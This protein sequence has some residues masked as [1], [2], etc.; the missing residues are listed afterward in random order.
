[1]S[2]IIQTQKGPLTK[3]YGDAQ[4]A[5]KSDVTVRVNGSE[6]TVDSVNPLEGEITL[7]NPVSPADEVEIDYY[8]TD[9]PIVE[10]EFNK[11]GILFNQNGSSNGNRFP[12]DSKFWSEKRSQPIRYDWTYNAYD[13]EYS[14]VFNDPTSL[15]F[16]EE[17]H[18][19]HVPAFSRRT[20]Q[21]SFL[22]EGD[23]NPIGWNKQGSGVSSP[24]FEQGLFV[25]EDSSSGYDGQAEFY[26][27][28]KD[29]TYEYVSLYGFRN[30]VLSYTKD[31]DFS[32]VATG[33]ADEG[34]LYFLGFLEVNGFRFVGL[35]SDAGDETSWSS[36]Q[37]YTTNSQQ[38]T[39]NGSTK[40]DQ[41]VFSREPSF[42]DGDA[43]FIDGSVYKVDSVT[44][45]SGNWNV[46]L[47]AEIGKTG[48]LEVFPEIDWTEL[49]SYR[50]TR[51][52]DGSVE[53]FS[54]SQS[55]PVANLVLSDAP[56]QPEVFELLESNQL[57]FGSLSRDATNKVGW[58]FARYSF[59]PFR[60]SI[61]QEQQVFVESDFASKKPEEDENNPWFLDDNQG[62]SKLVNPDSLLIEQAGRANSGSYTYS[63]IEPF[64]GQNNKVKLTTNIRAE[65]YADGIASA[66]T[67]ADPFKEVTVA[68]LSD[69]SST[70][71]TDYA[72]YR[73]TGGKIQNNA[74]S[75]MGYIAPVTNDN[76]IFKYK[77]AFSGA[78]YFSNE[79]WTSDLQNEATLSFQDHH[80]NIQPGSSEGEAS[81]E[82]NVLSGTN[83]FDNYLNSA[84]IRINDVD[85]DGNGR[86]PLWFG[87]NDGLDGVFLSFIEESGTNKVAFVREDGSIVRDSLGDS[88]SVAFDWDDNTFH[89]YRVIRSGNTIT[90]FID[91]S[92][93]GLTVL[94]SELEDSTRTDLRTS[95]HTGTTDGSFDVDYF[96]SHSTEYADQ[97]IGLFTGTDPNNPDHYEKMPYDWLGSYVELRVLKDASGRTEV[98]VDGS[99]TPLF[100]KQH[101]E[102]PDRTDRPEIGTDLGYVQFG[103]PDPGS[104]SH[105]LWDDISY[106]IQNFREFQ[107]INRQARYNT[108]NVNTS[109][110]PIFDQDP[111]V[112]TIKSDTKN[113]IRF[114]SKGIYP[115]RVLSVENEDGTTSYDF[116]FDEDQGL[117]TITNGTLPEQRTPLKVVFYEQDPKTQRY[118][119]DQ[120]ANTK[121]N[122]GTPPFPLSQQAEVESILS[123]YS[124]FV[125]DDDPYNF[126]ISYRLV[127]GSLRVTYE[128]DDCL[129]YKNL[130]IQ[131]VKTDG[132]YGLLSPACDGG[133]LAGLDIGRYE[134]HYNGPEPDTGFK[135]KRTLRVDRTHC[136]VDET[137]CVVDGAFLNGSTIDVTLSPSLSEAYSG[138][139]DAEQGGEIVEYGGFIVDSQSSTTDETDPAKQK[140]ID[141]TSFTTTSIDFTTSFP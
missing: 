133:G 117:L 75:T 65:S 89:T 29:L 4:L 50:M 7:D 72:T 46:I 40:T 95:F 80:L 64:L 10:A 103:S 78:D 61:E 138:A 38:R 137:E 121:L 16:N 88:V 2:K 37:G 110:E 13:Y 130:D 94:A 42:Q 69:F 122:E 34:Y 84:R 57:F 5:D 119:Q 108:Y 113:E 77:H 129:L 51:L 21:E 123:T 9:W 48:S 18:G 93:S 106:A 54:G 135:N 24:V 14:A 100:E 43:L 17:I 6:V 36:Y 131:G 112:L 86:A 11:N 45:D 120:P 73:V 20:K 15:V 70:T 62:Y 53:V 81:L 68:L 102:L 71:L 96:F 55:F 91:G 87:T 115:R 63:R 59:I 31:G 90:L 26:W 49:T 116:L 27:R 128:V 44:E 83:I 111:E 97:S 3:G 132:K 47:D 22:F 39:V 76:V 141:S 104:F 85:L 101:S 56:D 28:E 30:K 32:G 60:S 67:I 140:E 35:L 8:Y 33:W 1:M 92:F 139:T 134:D 109:P 125:D 58:D 66:V 82:A 19:P 52:S 126:D 98:F 99:S 105:A 124:A 25:I 127:D 79:G 136:K 23:Q 107:S 74:H 41:L 12:L 114:A 118:L